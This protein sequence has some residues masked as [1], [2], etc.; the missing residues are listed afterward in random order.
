[1]KQDKQD[2]NISKFNKSL[3]HLIMHCFQ[4][5]NSHQNYFSYKSDPLDK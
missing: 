1:M 4:T 2:K 5:R 3:N